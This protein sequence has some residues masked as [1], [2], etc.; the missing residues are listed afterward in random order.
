MPCADKYTTQITITGVPR[1]PSTAYIVPH[2]AVD[3]TMSS[4]RTLLMKVE[5]TLA[6]AQ[7]GKWP[8]FGRE[9]LTKPDTSALPP[10]DNTAAVAAAAPPV[11]SEST[12]GQKPKAPA[13]P[14]SSRT[15][16]KDWEN[17]TKAEDDDEAEGG[18]DDFFKKLYGNSSDDQKR[19]MMKSF[20]ESNGTTLSTNWD[21][22]GAAPVPTN[23]PDGVIA[24]KWNPTK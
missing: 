5:L 10:V 18:V 17:I 15:G 4:S 9:E 22:V 19:A 1:E 6:K 7:P 3:P 12:N 16:P 14:T 21:E 2:A 13:Y 8:T 24:K 23:P 20:Q 11:L